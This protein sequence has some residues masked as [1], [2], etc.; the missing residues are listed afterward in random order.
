MP[1]GF[2]LNV[3]VGPTLRDCMGRFASISNPA[4]VLRASGLILSA[5]QI[6]LEIEKQY[7]PKDTGVFAGSL[8]LTEF[9]DMGFA[10]TTN[11]AHLLEWIRTGT[12]VYAGGSMISAIHARMMVFN[13]SRWSRA[14]IAPNFGNNFAFQFIRGMKANAWEED[15]AREIM[16]IITPMLRRAAAVF[17]A[18]IG[19][20]KVL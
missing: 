3:V 4:A 17:Q 8:Y 18:R 7:A 19:L 20:G 2:S 9:G 1:S 10:V 6:A 5:G 14:P 16:P 11:N 12:G 15:A 13:A